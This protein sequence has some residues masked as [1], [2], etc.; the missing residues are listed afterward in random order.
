MFYVVCYVLNFII[1]GKGTALIW[2]KVKPDMTIRPL[3]TDDLKHFIS[4]TDTSYFYLS[5][6]PSTIISG[7]LVFARESKSVVN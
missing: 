6:G 7:Y 4:V 1:M 3:H 2:Y 5:Y